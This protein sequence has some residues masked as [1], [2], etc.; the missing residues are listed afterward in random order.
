MALPKKQM[1]KG[2]LNRKRQ[3][4]QSDSSAN[5]PPFPTDIS[6]AFP[7]QFQDLLL[8]DSCSGGDRLVLLGKR[9]LLD[10]LARAKLWLA[11]RT[12]KVAPSLF[13]QLYTMHFELVPRIN[14]AAVYCLLQ[15][16]IQAVY[17]RV[18]DEIERM[19][20]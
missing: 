20:P 9:A 4:L 10:R 18:L 15:N 5:L 8:F 14:T 12:F 2:T 13:F 16:K 1:L 11:D 6:F 17:V 7:D 19:I 3:K